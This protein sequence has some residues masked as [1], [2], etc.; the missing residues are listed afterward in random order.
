VPAAACCGW[1]CA[2]AL[3]LPA[4]G[5]A[6]DPAPPGPER[7]PLGGE[8]L[9][10]APFTREQRFLEAA[11][12]GDRATLARA[13]ELGVPVTAKDDLGRGALLLAARDAGSLEAVRFLRERGA[14]LDEPDLGGRTALSF[15][16]G[17]GRLDLVQELAAHGARIDLPDEEGRTPLF[18]A[19]TGDHRDT[20]AWLLE[21]GAAVDPVGQF[22]D[23]PLMLA[24]AKGYGALAAFLVERGADPARRDQ[25]GRT[26][27]DRAAPGVEACL[28]SRAR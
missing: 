17:A 3:L 9:A 13:L 8:P 7:G 27:R 21:R 5:F 24:C 14:P 2:L 25:E 26:A 10:P 20:V 23:T 15:A 12:Q 1:I 19:V 28:G 4:A 22:G 16:A 18:H 6:A 11:R